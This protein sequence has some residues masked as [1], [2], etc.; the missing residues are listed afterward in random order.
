MSYHL[1]LFDF[2]G[3]LVD[4]VGDIAFYANQVLREFG[5]HECSVEQVKRSIGLGVHELLKGVSPSFGQDPERLDR[6]VTLFKK[7][8]RQKPVRE[9][10]P[11]PDVLEVLSGPL[12]NL[13]KAIITN[14]P[15]EITL[16]IL[17]VLNMRHFFDRVIGM[18]AGYAPKPDPES[19]LATM[20]TFHSEA[21]STVFIGDSRIDAQTCQNA[22]IDFVWVDYGY[23]YAEGFLPRFKF[24][25]AK[26]WETLSRID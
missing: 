18:H 14:K 17:N 19:T 25:A 23:G 11:F 13:P 24:S 1:F 15:Q 20:K 7:Y 21:A 16:E 8:Y 22:G 3:T 10:K 2:D 4:T 6:A 12:R 26:E 5:E 9:T